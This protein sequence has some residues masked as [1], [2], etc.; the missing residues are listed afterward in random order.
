MV[1]FN[2]IINSRFCTTLQH[3]EACSTTAIT[4]NCGFIH[5]GLRV[6]F[7]LLPSSLGI[8]LTLPPSATTGVSF[9]MTS[10]SQST[11]CLLHPWNFINHSPRHPAVPPTDTYG[12][13]RCRILVPFIHLALRGYNSVPAIKRFPFSIGIGLTF[14]LSLA[15]TTLLASD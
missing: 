13:H 9:L 8:R 11:F 2:S 6:R 7:I 5:Y 4:H 15:T 12:I 3:F 14:L 1:C 10:M